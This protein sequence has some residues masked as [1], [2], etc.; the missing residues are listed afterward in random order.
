MKKFK[1]SLIILSGLLIPFILYNLIS[2][3]PGLENY[4][5]FYFY[6]T[7]SNYIGDKSLFSAIVLY[8]TQLIV[9]ISGS[10]I[11]SVIAIKKTGPK[12]IVGNLAAMVVVPFFTI[13]GGGWLFQSIFGPSYG[14]IL[15]FIFSVSFYFIRKSLGPSVWIWG[16]LLVSS[17]GFIKIKYD[18]N[19][20]LA[21]FLYCSL[22]VL[23]SFF[24]G[25][26]G[27]LKDEFF[28]TKTSDYSTLQN[29][30]I[31]LLLIPLSIIPAVFADPLVVLLVWLELKDATIITLFIIS[32][33]VLLVIEVILFVQEY[34]RSTEIVP[35]KYTNSSLNKKSDT[36]NKIS[37]PVFKPRITLESAMNELNSMIGMNDVKQQ[38][39]ELANRI[40]M[41]QIRKEKGITSS[42]PVIHIVLTGNP[43]T[44]KTTVARILAKVFYAIGLLPTANLIETDRAD[45]VAGYI[46]QT[47][48]KTK[49]V[50]D[51]AMGGVLFI[52]EAY[53][54]ASSCEND[55]GREAIDTL[56]KRMEDDR[57]KFIVI[58]AGYKKQMKNFINSNPGL[59]S[60]FTTY[61]D[62][63]D[64][65][66]DELMQI[67]EVFA[68]KEGIIISPGAKKLM[69]KKI[70]DIVLHKENN[71]ANGRTIRELVYNKAVT[72]MDNRLAEQDVT[73]ITKNDLITILPEDVR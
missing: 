5:I 60:R 71:F 51:D 11:F 4:S 12:R 33:I 55:F 24:N 30:L 26:S 28:D 14:F 58:V 40:K 25:L 6:K 10:I 34:Y 46:G 8:I 65:N 15:G 45:L 9:F 64:Y 66:S 41:N 38:V 23:C 31:L 3:L 68:K 63:S 39:Q 72:K 57:G 18:D 36:A 53:A 42:D 2:L 13:I 70:D 56:L 21:Y 43:G 16:I 22:T 59:K 44:G 54:L 49:K 73:K 47:A 62:I 35:Y 32:Y 1:T 17:F 29:I 61:I 19:V 37:P 52:D 48:I 20:K 27:Y 69:Q 7:F 50:C 67:T